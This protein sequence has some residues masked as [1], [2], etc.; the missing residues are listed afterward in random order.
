ML[1][2]WAQDFQLIIA[3]INRIAGQEVRAL[4]HVHWWTF[5]AWYMEIGDCLFAQVVRIRDKRARNRPLD[6][7]DREFYR[8]NRDLIDLKANYTDAEKN[9]LAAWGVKKAAL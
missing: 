3:P 7:Q 2:D 4:D 1:V 8:K 5:L 9:L 6:K